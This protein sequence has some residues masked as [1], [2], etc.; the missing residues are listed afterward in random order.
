MINIFEKEPPENEDAEI[1]GDGAAS[2][3]QFVEMLKRLTKD[4][5]EAHMKDW[6]RGEDNRQH[7]TC[8][9]E[10]NASNNHVNINGEQKNSNPELP[11]P[12]N[13]EPELYFEIAESSL[14][15]KGI[16]KFTHTRKHSF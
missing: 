16:K 4:K 11:D 5:I 13:L 3:K 10:L 14:H 15:E 2:F 1:T 7:T 12:E 8:Q 9:P 6:Q